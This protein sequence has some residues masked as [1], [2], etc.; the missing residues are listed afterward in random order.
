MKTVEFE[1][2][3]FLIL[4]SI[5]DHIHMNAWSWKLLYN[6]FNVLWELVT[7]YFQHRHTLI[8]FIFQYN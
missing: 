3:R 7:F 5:L 6:M 8:A 1:K 2:G 4:E